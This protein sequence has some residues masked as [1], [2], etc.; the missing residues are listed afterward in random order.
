MDQ[1]KAHPDFR[2]SDLGKRQGHE[3]QSR[4]GHH[5]VEGH[6]RKSWLQELFD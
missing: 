4:H 3:H 5:R 6:R 1:A 2:D